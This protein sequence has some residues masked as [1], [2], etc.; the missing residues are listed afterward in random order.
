[1]SDAAEGRIRC[2]APHISGLGRGDIDGRD[3]VPSSFF[4]SDVSLDLERGALYTLHDHRIPLAS[5]LRF[6]RAD[7]VPAAA[8]EAAARRSARAQAGA[9]AIKMR[10]ARRQPQPRTPHAVAAE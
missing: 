8:I 7:D 4:V 5:T 6:H 2:F 9:L 1:V 10:A 3:P